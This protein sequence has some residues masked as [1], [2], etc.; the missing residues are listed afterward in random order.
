MIVWAILI[1]PHI[2]M[3]VRANDCQ[4]NVNW[5]SYIR[6]FGEMIIKEMCIDQHKKWLIL[7]EKDFKNKWLWKQC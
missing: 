2:K 4:G 7:M 3:I 1:D 6:I 5:F